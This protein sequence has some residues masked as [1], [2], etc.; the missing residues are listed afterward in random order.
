[1]DHGSPLLEHSAAFRMGRTPDDK[2]WLETIENGLL[3]AL[4]EPDF[5]T[6]TLFPLLYADASPGKRSYALFAEDRRYDQIIMINRLAY[7]NAGMVH[8]CGIA[9]AGKAYIFVGRSGAG[10]TTLAR[11]WQRNGAIPDER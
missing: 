5:R 7:F 11:S 1:M 6:G 10:K 8:C 9:I 4:M 2:I 3:T